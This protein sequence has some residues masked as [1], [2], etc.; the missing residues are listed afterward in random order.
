[1]DARRLVLEITE[2]M[3]L[4]SLED[5]IPLLEKLKNRGIHIA[6]DDF[7]TGYSSLNYL[8]RL[9]IDALKIDKAFVQD[10]ASGVEAELIL[11]EMI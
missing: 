1:M 10:I 11:G 9:P 2:S 4:N 3:L 8:R 7:G 5:T 6:L